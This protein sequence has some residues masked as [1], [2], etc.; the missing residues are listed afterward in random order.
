MAGTAVSFRNDPEKDGDY[1]K[2]IYVFKALRSTCQGSK[3]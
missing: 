1:E 2:I 3:V